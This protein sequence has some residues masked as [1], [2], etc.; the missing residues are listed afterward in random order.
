MRAAI[1]PKTGAGWQSIGETRIEESRAGEAV[2]FS[3]A[4][5]FAL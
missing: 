2:A 3:L 1:D 5:I 4:A